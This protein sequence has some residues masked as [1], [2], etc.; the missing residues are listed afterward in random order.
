VPTSDTP[1]P[2]SWPAGRAIVL[3]HWS[4]FDQL[5]GDVVVGWSQRDEVDDAGYIHLEEETHQPARTRQ[6]DRES[7][8]FAVVE[9]HTFTGLTPL[10]ASLVHDDGT[11]VAWLRA[12]LGT[13]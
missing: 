4:W 2:W 10:P 12:L 7:R 1:Q 13:T 3:Y 11:P 5:V 6:I 9:P 8:D